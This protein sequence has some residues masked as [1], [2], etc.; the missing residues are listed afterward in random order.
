MRV[1]AF[2][3]ALVAVLLVA[4]PARAHVRATSVA[5]DLRSQGDGVAA[6]VDV[7]YDVLARVC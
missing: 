6:V 2:L 4:A 5:V 7:E 1:L 3:A